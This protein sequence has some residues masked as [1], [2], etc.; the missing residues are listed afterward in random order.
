MPVAALSPSEGRD[1][2]LSAVML[3]VGSRG[4]D[5]LGVALVAAVA[6]DR[7]PFHC[8]FGAG[9][10]LDG[11]VVAVTGCASSVAITSR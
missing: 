6:H 9:I 4:H 11:A 2:V 3:L 7:T 10:A 8:P 1:P 5:R